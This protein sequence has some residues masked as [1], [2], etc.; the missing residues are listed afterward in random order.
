MKTMNVNVLDNT[1]TISNPQD[2]DN[3]STLLT[4]DF[5]GCG[6]DALAKWV[7]FHIADG[8]Q[9][10]ISLGTSI[11]GTYNIPNS[12]MKEGDLLLQA[13]ATSGSDLM[14]KGKVFRIPIKRSLNVTSNTE[15]YDIGVVEALQDAIS[16]ALIQV[17]AIWEAYNNGD[18]DGADG[19]DGLSAYEIALANGF[20]GTQAQWLTSLEGTDGTNGLNG[21]SAY[22]LA[23]IDGF[24]GT[25]AEWIASLKGE[26]GTT[27]DQGLSAYEVAVINGYVGTEVQWLESLNGTDGI[28][29]LDGADAVAGEL[30]STYVELASPQGVTSATFIDVPTMTDTITLDEA[31]NIAVMVSFE[32]QTISGSSASTIE[33]AIN[34]DGVDHDPLKRYLSGTNDV[35][36]GAIVHRT[37][38]AVSAG[39]HTVTLRFRRISG[40][41]TPA[42]NR[43]HMLIMAMQGAKGIQGITGDSGV[44]V[45]DVEPTDPDVSVWIDPDEPTDLLYDDFVELTDGGET[46]LHKHRALDI[47]NTPSGNISSTTV[48]GAINELDIEKSDKLFATNLVTNGDFSN[49][50]TGWTSTQGTIQAI[51]NECVL[52]LTGVASGSRIEQLVDNAI[53]GNVYYIV[54]EILPL[55]ANLTYIIN[56]SNNSIIYKLLYS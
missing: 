39:V 22:E 54:G 34:I 42:I 45:G 8:T 52:T 47:N 53:I 46:L 16:D 5:T 56:I 21:L 40:I 29:G 7:D 44:Y 28:D 37:L 27:G 48:Q 51:N 18:L 14:F 10:A 17:D 4:V 31:V 33:V 43:A 2:G 36:I 23:L 50:T 25:E 49:G 20:V 38:I 55:Y 30:P 15:D 41:S 12:I 6:V 32:L 35:G 11:I 13:Y 19:I 9:V 24:V 3:N 26:V 1:I